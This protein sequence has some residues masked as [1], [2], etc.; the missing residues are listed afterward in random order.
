[1]KKITK[2]IACLALGTLIAGTTTSCADDLREEFNDPDQMTE[3]QFNLLFSSA[4]TQTHLF[5]MEYGPTYHNQ[6]NFNKMLGL[7]IRPDN[8]DASKNNSIIQPWLGWSGVLFNDQIFTKT[9]VDYSKNLNAMDLL[10][11]EMS[12]EEQVQNMAY[13]Y[14]RNIVS[15]YAF[16]RSTD[17]Y[18]DLPYFGA[19]GAF[20]GEFYVK[21]DSQEAIYDDI[22]KKLKDAANGLAT[23]KFHS[24]VKE[25]QFKGSDILCKGDLDKWIRLANSLR[26]RMA[27]RLCHVKPDVAQSTIRE[28]INGDRLITEYANNV[29][30]EEEDK[31]HAFELTFFRGLEERANEC[32]APETMIQGFMNYKYQ[33]GDENGISEDRHDFDPRL[34][35]MFQPDKHGRYIGMPMHMAD[36]VKLHEY[37]TDQEIYDLIQLDDYKDSPWSPTRLVTMYNRRTYFNFDMMYP[38]IHAPEVHL[39]LAEA[40]VRWPGVFSDINPAEH[41]KKAIDISTRFYYDTNI[42]NKYSEA[43]NPALQ[44]LKPSAEA[45]RLNE[46]H[47]ADY[48]DFVA[49][50]FNSLTSVQDK[51]KLIFDQKY[52]DMNIM[53]PYE[54]YN[55]TRR[56]VKDFNGELPI[57]PVPNVVFMDRFLYPDSESQDNGENFQEVAHKNNH[58]TPVWWSNRTTTAVNTNGDAL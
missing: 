47:L 53:N 46:A 44:Y 12:E 3:P 41:I 35:A 52:L 43:T 17:L 33:Q 4:L 27:M 29:G 16:Q 34:Y 18:D 37:Y 30:I 14:C 15:A 8:L 54:I 36:T 6:I 1:M 42:S 19:G 56:L 20:H 31:T 48:C 58:T 11:A 32:V 45:P 38:V 23:F 24:D 21:Y 55:E 40:A 22:M 10:F 13:V 57:I 7:C 2:Y 28:L 26:L 39:L 49:K 25:T 9:M 50:K 51:Y 5:R